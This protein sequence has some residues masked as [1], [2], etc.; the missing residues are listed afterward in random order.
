V[1]IERALE[2]DRSNVT[3]HSSTLS[4]LSLCAATMSRSPARNAL[5]MQPDNPVAL[6]GFYM[7]LAAQGMDKEALSAV[8]DY[9]GYTGFPVSIHSGPGF[10]EA[11]FR[12]ADEACAN[13]L[14]ERAR[15]NWRSRPMS[16]VC[17]STL[18]IGIAPWSGSSELMRRVIRTCP[19]SGFQ[20]M[21]PCAPTRASSPPASHE[22]TLT[23]FRRGLT[24]S[25][26]RQRRRRA[27]LR[28]DIGSDFVRAP[29]DG[30]QCQLRECRRHRCAVKASP[31]PLCRRRWQKSRVFGTDDVGQQHTAMGAARQ[32][33][34]TEM[35]VLCQRREL[36]ARVAVRAEHFGDD[37]ELLVIQFQHVG[38]L[39]RGFDKF[40]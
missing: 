2:L 31:A 6:N 15:Q 40:R 30:V 14:A 10:T 27:S 36:F 1:Q 28:A 13:V 3:I 16:P 8:K 26:P 18:T 32:C 35:E 39:E 19:I 12:G 23:P 21:T 9:L 5:K 20:Y 34:G 37:R 11:G 33:D 24:T 4:I 38:Q 7:A 22:I 29:V 25:G 17:T